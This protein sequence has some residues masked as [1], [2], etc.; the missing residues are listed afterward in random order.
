MQPT[1]ETICRPLMA[2]DP[3]MLHRGSHINAQPLMAQGGL[4]VGVHGCF[5]RIMLIKRIKENQNVGTSASSKLACL[6]HFVLI[7]DHGA[8]AMTSMHFM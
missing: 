3:K 7:L 6:C 5:L 8:W 2:S 4:Y 1:L